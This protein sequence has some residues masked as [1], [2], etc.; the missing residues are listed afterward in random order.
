MNYGPH[1]GST[2]EELFIIYHKASAQEFH[3]R[4]LLSHAQPFWMIQREAQVQDAFLALT[5]LL[6]QPVRAGYV[7]R[8]DRACEALLLETHLG[9][10]YRKTP[11]R[12]EQV[13]DTIRKQIRDNP[14]VQYDFEPLARSHGLSASTFRRYWNLYVHQ[15]P[16]RYVTNL[17]IRAACR[18]LVETDRSINEI[19]HNTGFED[20]FYFSRCFRSIM[21]LPPR[22]YRQQHLASRVLSPPAIYPSDR[23]AQSLNKC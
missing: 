7:D 5:D 12:G 16:A 20:P 9:A 6:H 23:S 14:F 22:T 3:T 19:A 2:W 1:S 15:P 10:Q 18:M 4:K 13:V 17:R 21:H 11:S 8:V